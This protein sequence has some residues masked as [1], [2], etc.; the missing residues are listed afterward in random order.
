LAERGL[1]ARKTWKDTNADGREMLCALAALSAEVETAEDASACP[2]ALCPEWMAYVVVDIDDNVS[3]EAHQRLMLA[4][5]ESAR[6]WPALNADAWERIRR[7]WL[8]SV[9]DEAISQVTVDNWGVREAIAQVRAALRGE[10]DLEV[11]REAAAEAVDAAAD[12]AYAARTA[13]DAAYAAVD[14][15]A[16][17]A[18]A[19]AVARAAWAVAR[20]AAAGETA[21][22]A[23]RAA[24]AAA[25]ADAWA[26]AEAAA[27]ASAAT[28]R[29]AAAWDRMTEAL[30]RL[31]TKET[32]VR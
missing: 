9:L 10:G 12:A 2:A 5:G 25:A 7:A 20:A 14:A 28:A 8:C 16:E 31:I 23:A 11:A 27:T 32:A 3:D 15:A 17:A 29:G 1:V 26:T 19:A 6:R 24:A 30:L 21:A 18:W 13:A 22:D 4:L